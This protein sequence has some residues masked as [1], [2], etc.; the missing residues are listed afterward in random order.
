MQ[1]DAEGELLRRCIE[2][3]GG[4]GNS[5]TIVV[6]ANDC[7]EDTINDV[8][9]QLEQKGWLVEVLPADG[10]DPAQLVISSPPIPK[11][12]PTAQAPAHPT[13]A[14]P[15]QTFAESMA[16]ENLR[17]WTEHERA[18]QSGSSPSSAVTF[19]ASKT[20]I[21]WATMAVVVLA[22]LTAAWFLYISPRRQL[23]QL[24]K[25]T[26]NQLDGSIMLAAGFTLESAI[27]KA[28]RLGFSGPE[29]GDRMREHCPSIMRQIADFASRY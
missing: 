2:S 23:D 6:D 5:P 1:I 7:P 9:E 26:C 11:Q 8:A 15:Q 16:A 20:A 25:D 10:D 4:M 3:I 21:V 24:A 17:K 18:R 12:V 27:N 13:A 19:T 28:E 29:L 14:A 22:A